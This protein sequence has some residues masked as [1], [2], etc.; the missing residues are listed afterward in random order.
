[1][2]IPPSRS[3]REP[4]Q[5][6]KQ[7]KIPV[8]EITKG[9]D[10]SRLPDDKKNSE[11]IFNDNTMV[12]INNTSEPNVPVDVKPESMPPSQTRT[13]KE[14]VKPME[15]K[16]NLQRAENKDSNGLHSANISPTKED[17]PPSYPAENNLLTN[18]M[19]LEPQFG[20]ERKRRHDTGM[21]VEAKPQYVRNDELSSLNSK[22]LSFHK[23]TEHILYKLG[24]CINTSRITSTERKIDI[25]KQLWATLSK[26]NKKVLK[27]LM[28]NQ[29]NIA[30]SNFDMSMDSR[31]YYSNEPPQKI[32]LRY[33]KP[34]I[35]ESLYQEMD[36][37][38]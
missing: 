35:I 20:N 10:E 36:M 24:E 26:D 2:S 6:P 33:V 4:V 22:L 25:I 23:K 17:I 5:Q 28:K 11:L 37:L 29:F 32:S 15:M 38:S 3:N 19:L 14:E 9:G 21:S 1:M 16:I 8:P 34:S 13:A 12:N 31:S 30:L 7:D 27:I 18:E